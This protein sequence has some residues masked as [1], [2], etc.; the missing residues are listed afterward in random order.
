MSRN[1]SGSGPQADESFENVPH[2]LRLRFIGHQLAAD[3]VVAQG[4]SPPIHIPF[5]FEKLRTCFLLSN[6]ACPDY[7]Q[8]GIGQD[9]LKK[10]MI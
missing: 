9:Q 4:Y 10:F 7:F 5:F 8:G 1:L 6:D 3:H 2:Q